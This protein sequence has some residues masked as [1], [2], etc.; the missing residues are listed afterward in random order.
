MSQGPQKE[1][2]YPFGHFD[3][4]MDTLNDIKELRKNI[5]PLFFNSSTSSVNIDKNGKLK[6]ELETF[7]INGEFKTLSFEGDKI[8]NIP[9]ALCSIRII[10]VQPENEKMNTILL[11]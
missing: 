5:N 3:N 4:I 8:K 9:N 7:N 1:F 10:G 2:Q 6:I 11:Y